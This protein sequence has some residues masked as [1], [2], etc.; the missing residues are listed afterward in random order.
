MLV[1]EGGV[2]VSSFV[3]FPFL[4]DTSRDKNTYIHC[5]WRVVVFLSHPVTVRQL[6][7]SFSDLCIRVL[8]WG[9]QLGIFRTAKP[10]FLHASCSRRFLF[11][12][13]LQLA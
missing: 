10:E 1:L 4:I 8:A 11:H 2:V 12:F 9:V 3:L 6:V 7:A 5:D 13:F